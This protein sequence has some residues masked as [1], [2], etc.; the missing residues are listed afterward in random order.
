[1]Y[2]LLI[3]PFGGTA[4]E[5]LDCLGQDYRCMGFVSD[6]K[7]KI[8]KSY[9]GVEV[10]DREAL[11]R[12]PNCKILA[13]PGSPSSYLKRENI[14]Y[15]LNIDR[16]RFARVIHP[17]A[18]ISE[19]ANLGYNTLIGPGVVITSNAR[20]GNHVCILP[21]SVVHHDSWVGD[22]TIIGSNVTIAGHVV[23]G[24]HC[25]LGSGSNVINNCSVADQTLIGMGS[26]VIKS[27]LTAGK[28]VGS[29]VR[30]IN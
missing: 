2:D 6:D 9:A 22:Y 21:N 24:S 3:F 4:I 13:V 23:I 10:F 15:S 30:K 11:A 14:I 5:A 26:T 16:E 28:Y 8:G 7:D 17:S 1:M 27:L 29:P 19:L 25:Y 18:V 20:I 12:F